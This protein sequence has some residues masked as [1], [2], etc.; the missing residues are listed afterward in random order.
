VEL[1]YLREGIHLR[2]LAQTDPLVAWQREAYLMFGQLSD[3][4]SDDYLQHVFHV[5]W[6]EPEPDP[7]ADLSQATYLASEDP[8]DASA[9]GTGDGRMASGGSASAGNGNGGSN[10]RSRS[11]GLAGAGV[12]SNLDGVTSASRAGTS[13]GASGERGEGG[14]GGGVRVAGTPAKPQKIGRNEPCYC[15]SGKKFKLCHGAN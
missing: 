10:G 7:E 12:G 9:L 1:D 14:T 15:G 11:A 4:I 6:A 5:S 3:G 13:P 2:G 8:S